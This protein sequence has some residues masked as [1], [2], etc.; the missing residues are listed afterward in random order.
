MSNATAKLSKQRAIL[1]L[2]LL[3]A[4]AL[5]AAATTSGQQQQPPPLNR[6]TLH[7]R[8]NRS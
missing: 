5:I 8:K 4:I 3:S 1:F 6:L 7:Q 2:V